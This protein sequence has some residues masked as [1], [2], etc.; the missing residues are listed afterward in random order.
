MWEGTQSPDSRATEGAPTGTTESPIVQCALRFAAFGRLCGFGL[1]LC[2]QPRFQAT[3][4][5][6]EHMRQS[7]VKELALGEPPGDT[8]A[9]VGARAAATLN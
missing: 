8:I 6:G 7:V 3:F 9:W 1:F 5:C 4:F 2:R